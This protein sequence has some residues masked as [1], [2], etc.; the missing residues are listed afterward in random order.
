MKKYG[1]ISLIFNLLIV[2]LEIIGFF[3]AFQNH[4]ISM[5]QYYTQDSNLILLFSSIFYSMYLI[6]NKKIPIWLSSLK[7]MSTLSVLITFIVSVSILSWS[8]PGG[9]LIILFYESMLYHHTLC[10]ILAVISFI[11]FEKYD[12]KSKESLNRAMYFTFL[13][14]IIFIILNIFKVVEGPYPF[15]MVYKQPIYVSFLW[16]VIIIGGS[17]LLAKYLRYLN[18]RFSL[19]K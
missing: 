6:I 13:Y 15:L 2:L 19:N 9:L 1:F 4:G 3:I 17:Y 18:H 16:A 8:M 11:F 7:Y 14:A 12:I 10:P 5:L